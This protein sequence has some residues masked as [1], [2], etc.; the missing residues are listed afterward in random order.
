VIA[1]SYLYVPGDSGDRLERAPARGA[2]A[3]IA[4]LEDAVAPAR[5]SAAVEAVAGWL[6]HRDDSGV[7][8]WV[9]V[10]AGERGPDDLR[11]VYGPGLDGVVIPKA[12]PD[13]VRQIPRY[14]E[15]TGAGARCNG[16]GRAYAADRDRPRSA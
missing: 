14:A 2:D 4:D 15:R 1:R 10:N 12:A 11:A 16:P 13:E 8:R 6:A 5:K 7:Q 3:V 9:R